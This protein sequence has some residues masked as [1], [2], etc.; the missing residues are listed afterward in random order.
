MSNPL[1]AALRCID[2]KD[3]GMALE[4]LTDLNA[5]N[6]RDPQV[7][8]W[9]GVIYLTHGHA[10]RAIEHL[11]AAAKV[12]KKEAVIFATLADA[13]TLDNRFEEALP[14][15]RKAVAL[16]AKSEFAHRT[17][18]EIYARLRRPVMAEHAFQN[19]LAINEASAIAHLALSRLKVS[20]GKMDEAET[21]FRRALELAP[22]EPSVLISA[23]DL[24]DLSLKKEALEKIETLLNDVD[25]PMAKVERA[26]LAFT[27]GKICD[28]TG[29]TPKAF[30]YLGQHRNDLYGHYDADRQ[31]RHFETCR[32]VFS[33][34]FFEDRK[35]FALTSDRPVFVFGMPRSGTSLVEAILSAHPKA[36]AAG[37]LSFF[38]EQVD[39]LTE[40]HTGDNA[41]FDAALAL[42]RKSAQRIGRKY[43]TLLDGFSKKSA[44][45]IDKMPQNFEHLW[46]ITLLF[47]N[48]HFC[49]VSRNPA[50]T[51]VS[52][53]MTPLPGKH[54]YCESQQSL[55]HYYGQYRKLMAHWSTVL[56]VEIRNQ[57]YETLVSD[58]DTERPA[59]IS[60]AGLAWDEACRHHESNEAQV[61]TFSM[62]QV[63]QPIHTGAVNRFEKYR[64]HIGPLLEGLAEIET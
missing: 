52:I 38:D 2:A 54:G 22:E 53:Y 44:R 3:Y 60:H 50:D 43:L 11:Q 57:S 17:L 47:P 28:D 24:S 15:A 55:A 19:A 4:I 6:P 42:D 13:L 16:D 12:A 46:L 40:G 35:D 49:H 26:R 64:D 21:H 14:Y 37:E 9:L 5:A 32:E 61:F 23:R 33:K 30:H 31:E 34:Q 18:G 56:P 48:A 59:L 51:C 63:R 1:E 10:S 29:D 36:T 7:N 62:A 20:L 41:F 39:G 25:R 8:H 45:V 27:A 58:P